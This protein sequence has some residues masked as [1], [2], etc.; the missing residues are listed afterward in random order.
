MGRKFIKRTENFICANC[1]TKVSGDGYTNHC[2]KCLWSR[3]VD[4]NPGDR[5]NN[6]RGL[7]EPIAIE[8]T[9][10]GYIIIHC[11]QKCKVSKR[12][13]VAENDSFQAILIIASKGRGG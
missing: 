5:K 4:I 13:K 7:M 1:K 12:N 6:C 11:C 10:K 2:P 3:H 9:R 8:I